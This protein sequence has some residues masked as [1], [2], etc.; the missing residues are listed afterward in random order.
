MFGKMAAVSQIFRTLIS[1]IQNFPAVSIVFLKKI[2]NP[3]FFATTFHHAPNYIEFRP[4]QPVFVKKPKIA[5]Y[6]LRDSPMGGSRRSKTFPQANPSLQGGSNPWFTISRSPSTDPRG[7]TAIP[8][9]SHPGGQLTLG[10]SRGGG[11]QGDGD[12]RGTTDFRAPGGDNWLSLL[13]TTDFRGPAGD[14]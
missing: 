12:P 4:S 13:G 7:T 9:G 5:E 11:S 3:N 8:G 2:K 10:G 6:H 14:N 1:M